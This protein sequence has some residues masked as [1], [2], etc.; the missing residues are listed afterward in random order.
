MTFKHETNYIRYVEDVQDRKLILFGGGYYAQELLDK[1]FRHGEVFQIWD[2]NPDKNGRFL[3]GYCISLPPQKLSENEADGFVVI[4]SIIDDISSMSIRKQLYKLGIRHIYH[5]SIMY[6]SNDRERYNSYF[7]MK[8]HEKNTYGIVCKNADKI[9][10]VLDLLED[11][12]SRFVYEK[13][14]YKMKYNIGNYIDVCDDL[15]D[16]YFSDGIFA[17]DENEVFIDGGAYLGED[18]I[19]LAE[20]IG[21][22]KIKRAYCF[23]PDIMNYYKCISSLKKY[24]GSLSENSEKGDEYTSEQFNVYRAGLW[25]TEEKICFAG[26]GTQSASIADV[27]AKTLSTLVST[28]RIDDVVS[29]KDKVTLIKMDVEGAEMKALKGAEGIIKGDKPKMAISIYHKIED[30]W[31]I[32]MYIHELVPEYKLYVRHHT[33]GVWDS[34]L[35]AKID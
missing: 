8:F 27:K 12:K 7:D 25:D 14:I 3:N 4:I 5:F 23:E 19:R 28:C 33:E 9:Q 2:N 21:K 16:H 6:L 20:L 15:I 34:I 26:L 32:P 30:L 35:Y 13:I 18:T 1:W 17:Y 10:R 11:D 24:F 31:E 22:A 29:S